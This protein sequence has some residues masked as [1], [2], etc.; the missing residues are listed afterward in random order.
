MKVEFSS[1]IKKMYLL[2][3]GTGANFL[4]KVQKIYLQAIGSG[5]EDKKIVIGI[6]MG[7]LATTFIVGIII[8][9]S[10]GSSA[11]DGSSVTKGGFSKKF[12]GDY[13]FLISHTIAIKNPYDKSRAVVSGIT[14]S[15]F[16]GLAPITIKIMKSG[17][18]AYKGQMTITTL[19][20]NFG[21]GLMNDTEEHTYE[22]KNIM[23]S[24]D[25]LSFLI[26]SS[27]PY[28]EVVPFF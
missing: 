12:E 25:T 23:A 3:V 4:S 8:G 7:C 28:I 22:L 16:I 15:K 17:D 18:G 10:F 9:S 2:I 14:P 19:T 20:S 26:S 24:K 6:L 5:G 13:T 1:K 27:E 21:L 11:S